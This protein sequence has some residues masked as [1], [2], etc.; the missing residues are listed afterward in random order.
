MRMTEYEPGSGR[1]RTSMV[2][3]SLV[4]GFKLLLISRQ[5]E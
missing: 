1:R 5:I 3:I 2:F 4:I